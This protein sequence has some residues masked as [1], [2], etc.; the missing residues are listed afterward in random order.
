MNANSNRKKTVLTIPSKPL[1][2]LRKSEKN[3]HSV[4]NLLRQKVIRNYH[5]PSSPLSFLGHA[6]AF[7]WLA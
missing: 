7:Y 2:K 5:L 3:L 4:N 1:V 6:V